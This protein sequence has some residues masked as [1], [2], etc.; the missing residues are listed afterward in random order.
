MVLEANDI[1]L[2]LQKKYATI[3]LVNSNLQETL[4]E[5]KNNQDTQNVQVKESVDL[6]LL[7]ENAKKFYSSLKA[8]E[9]E[10]E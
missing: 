4:Y 3:E 2:E 10:L 1:L 9:K 8:E 6:N 5:Q 7:S